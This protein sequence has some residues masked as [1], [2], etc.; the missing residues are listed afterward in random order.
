MAISKRL[1]KRVLLIGWQGVDWP[2]IQASV[3]AGE[4]P[5]LEKLLRHS[6]AGRLSAPAPRFEES[7]WTCLV[8]GRRAHH[9]GVL[10]T[11][12]PL[13]S[14]YGICPV[15]RP[16]ITCATL[17][18][19]LSAAGRT[20]HQIGWPVSHPV[21]RLNGVAVSDR[22]A[23][24]ARLESAIQADGWPWVYPAAVV[25]E[26]FARR[27][28]SAE[29]DDLSVS[30]L[31]PAGLVEPSMSKALEEV[32]RSVLAE[33]LTV[34][35]AT[36]WCM[37]VKEWDCVLCSFSAIR[38]LREALN[39]PH[40][41][42][43]SKRVRKHILS[44]CCEQLDVLLGQF[45]VSVDDDT[46]VIIASMGH[47]QALEPM[48]LLRCPVAQ[49]DSFPAAASVLDVAP[50][51]LT[52]LGL[53][54]GE[55]M[56]GQA[57]ANLIRPTDATQGI[58]QQYIDTWDT[59]VKRDKRGQ[60]SFLQNA[61]GQQRGQDSLIENSSDPFIRQLLEWGYEDPQDLALRQRA[62]RCLWET[63]RNRVLS[64]LDAGQI[65]EAQTEVRAMKSRYP[66][67]VFPSETLT[68][69]YLRRE[70]W[71]DAERELNA[72]SQRGVVSA[73]FFLLL[74]R[75]ALGKRDF[76]QASQHF[77]VAER[78]DS[79]VRGLHFAWAAALLKQ[80]RFQQAQISLEKSL[81]LDGPTAT[82]FDGLAVCCLGLGRFE[83]AASYALDAVDHDPRF[84]P[85]HY[86]LAVALVYLGKQVEAKQALLT[87]VT[88]DPEFVAAWRRLG[89]LEEELSGDSSQAD[90][91]RGRGRAI[92]RRRRELRLTADNA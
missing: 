14:G 86:H 68:D 37:Q 9:H 72:L 32:C 41:A 10:H 25:K 50:T 15:T 24:Q 55:D 8:T 17:G 90:Q 13:E 57:W 59:H 21:E 51:V 22:F 89:R 1:T 91:Y 61:P 20:V 45:V 78:Q 34:F 26:I 49:G 38:R 47:P 48:L 75:L 6:I 65:D 42:G 88:V 76:Q 77:H 28:G 4:L 2:T 67:S 18:V 56:E 74:G 12:Q 43:L 5:S 58:T 71:N 33:S 16:Q 44:K 81:A 31:L 30:A 36:K 35:R 40:F 39:A 11:F 23:W 63:D 73:R 69:V 66:D 79:A 64:L 60:S 54:V 27:Y 62:E 52:L 29:V 87:C 83:E 70:Q 46:T 3:A 19:I 80:R 85:A 7:L 82:A 84:A 92:I 53:P